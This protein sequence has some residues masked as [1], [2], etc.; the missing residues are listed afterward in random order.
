MLKRQYISHLRSD[1]HLI[2]SSC[3]YSFM[4]TRILKEADNENLN[5]EEKTWVQQ[6]VKELFL[7][8]CGDYPGAVTI[9]DSHVV[10]GRLQEFD[11]NA[12]T[13]RLAQP[14][15]IRPGNRISRFVRRLL[16]E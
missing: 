3:R 10:F 7:H 9:R 5:P 16:P 2:T 11:N 4:L 8:L 1:P 12:E 15:K 13:R 14:P 6:M